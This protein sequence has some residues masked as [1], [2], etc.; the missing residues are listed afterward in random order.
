MRKYRSVSGIKRTA[1]MERVEGSYGPYHGSYVLVSTESDL[2][3]AYGRFGNYSDAF[4]WLVSEFGCGWVK[5]R[6]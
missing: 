4:D 6:D 2:G 5:V 1:T 3:H